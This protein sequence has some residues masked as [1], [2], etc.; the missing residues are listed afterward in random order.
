MRCLDGVVTGR[1]GDGGIDATIREDKLGLDEVYESKP[2]S[3]P[4]EARWAL[5][6]FGNLVGALV[7]AHARKGVFGTT[8]DFTASAKDFAAQDPGRVVLNGFRCT[9]GVPFWQ[10]GYTNLT[11]ASRGGLVLPEQSPNVA[12]VLA[13]DLAGVGFSLVLDRQAAVVIQALELAQQWLKINHSL[14]Q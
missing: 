10:Q 12:D 3:P 9:A 8:A 1:T 7:G 4:A 6:T 2:R 11:G 13:Q 5:A 14:P